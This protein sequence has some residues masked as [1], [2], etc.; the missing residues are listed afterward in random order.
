MPAA[1]DFMRSHTRLLGRRLFDRSGVRDAV[2]SYRN[3]DGGFGNAL[4]PDVRASSSQP[5]FVHFALTSLRDGGVR[6][7]DELA[8]TCDWL[9]SVANNDGAVPYLLADAFEHPRAAHWNGDW[10]S[11][12]SLIATSAVAG[13]MHAL[14]V[15]HEWLKRATAWCLREIDTDPAYTPHT[16]HNTLEFLHAM[17]EPDTARLERAA[18]RLMQGDMFLVD[19]PVAGYGITPIQYAPSPDHPLRPLFT[20]D[21]IDAHLDDLASRQ[22][23]DGGWPIS[24]EPPD[25]VASLE[26]RGAWTLA[27]VR[28]LTAYGRL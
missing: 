15:Q 1:A 12:P 17:P 16:L 25:G 27:A 9:A 14:G 18:T 28:T 5:L 3:D 23:E 10:C 24:W 22:A 4:E 11:T 13:G 8:A 7:P 21:L 2:F 26:W 20:D 6:G 19:T